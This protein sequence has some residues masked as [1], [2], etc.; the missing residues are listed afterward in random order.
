M[1]PFEIGIGYGY[2]P[3]PQVNSR[4]QHHTYGSYTQPNVVQVNASTTPMPTTIQEVIDRF[5]ANLAKQMRD[6]YGTSKKIKVFR[7]ENRILLVLI[8]FPIILVGVVLN[9]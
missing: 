9:L 4:L 2:T 3:N 6:D 8:R 7:I 5:N 1:V